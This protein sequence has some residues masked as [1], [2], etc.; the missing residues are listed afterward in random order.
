MNSMLYSDRKIETKYFLLSNLKFKKKYGGIVRIQEYGCSNYYGEEIKNPIYETGIKSTIKILKN[1][2]KPLNIFN[3]KFIIK[4]SSVSLMDCSKFNLN[5]KN[6]KGLQ[7][8]TRQFSSFKKKLNLNI[9]KMNFPYCK[10]TVKN[11]YTDLVLYKKN[12]DFIIAKNIEK[13]K[14][15]M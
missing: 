14:K 12:K 6:N 4:N 7:A 8:K 15:K 9:I 10:P 1:E 13:N 5:K 11:S 2:I 3:S